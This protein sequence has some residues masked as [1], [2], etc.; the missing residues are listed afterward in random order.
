[1]LFGFSVCI[2]ENSDQ[3]RAFKLKRLDLRSV[4]TITTVF[5]VFAYAVATSLASLTFWPT[6]GDAH[7]ILAA[8]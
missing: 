7:R 1:M 3:R 5:A 6:T 4:F 8:P 2:L